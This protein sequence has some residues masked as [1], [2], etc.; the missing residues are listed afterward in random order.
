MLA[1]EVTALVHGAAA[2]AAAEEATAIVFGGHRRAVQKA[3]SSRW[4]TRSP[5][6]GFHR[7]RP[8]TPAWPSSTSWSPPAWSASKG[9]ARRLLGQG[10]ATVGG[11]RPEASA[12][13]DSADLRFGRFL[14]LLR[15]GKRQVHLVVAE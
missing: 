11:V 5:P 10:G 1:R 12:E 6:P 7:A 4:S 2:L 8:S 14:L 3:P 15:K 13:I 9:E